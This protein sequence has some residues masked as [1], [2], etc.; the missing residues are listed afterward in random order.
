M[1]LDDKIVVFLLFAGVMHSADFLSYC[2]LVHLL[3]PSRSNLYFNLKVETRIPLEDLEFTGLMLSRD[4]SASSCV[5]LVVGHKQDNG[6]KP[7]HG[8]PSSPDGDCPLAVCGDT[9][10]NGND[11][12]ASTP[13]EP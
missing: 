12:V 13:L 2:V 6:E 1:W 5:A 11:S 7:Q 4:S 8:Q 9:P 10:T 3:W